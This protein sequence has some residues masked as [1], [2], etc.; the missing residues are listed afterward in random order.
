MSPVDQS[1]AIFYNMSK[2]KNGNTLCILAEVAGIPRQ[3]YVFQRL[4]KIVENYPIL[5]N[6]IQEK[7]GWFATNYQWEKQPAM[8]LSNH[9]YHVQKKRYDCRNFRRFMNKII[10]KDF[11]ENIPEWECYF[12]S[13]TETNKSFIIFKSN[14]VYGDGYLMEQFLKLFMDDDQ[15]KYPKKITKKPSILSKIY[16]LFRAVFSLL[17]FLIFYRKTNNSIDKENA[18]N[19]KN[20]FYHCKTWDMNDIKR[21]K[22]KYKV[23]VNDL[24]Y[25]ILTK[26]IQEY[27][28]KST[29]MSSVSMFN[30]R[31][32]TQ[33]N[34]N[35]QSS[36][37]RQNNIG[38]MSLSSNIHKYQSPITLLQNNSKRLSYYK[39]SPI[40]PLIIQSL[41]M[42]YLI[43]PK[44]AVKF[45]NYVTDKSTF[46]FSNFR[47]FSEPKSIQG[48]KVI[49]ISNMV[50]PYRLG[51]LFTLVSF[52]NNLTLNVVYKERNL[53]NPKKFM[54]CLNKV[55]K[56]FA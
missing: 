33:F 39:S 7:P 20:K 47:S 41:R 37:K 6:V 48:N 42:L 53:T 9:F 15:I 25:T 29:K 51:I 52:N 12:V 46:G 8:S 55:Y 54:K 10:N 23:S 17:Y 4:E 44:L 34:P 30:L 3:E 50:V 11:K 38:F 32:I 5:S 45:L 1:S 31:D 22:N 19:D 26:A 13:Y 36:M 18:D 56:Q 49:N 28:G 27:C 21:I 35:A 40:V 2:H 16:N 14:H 24:M 43:S